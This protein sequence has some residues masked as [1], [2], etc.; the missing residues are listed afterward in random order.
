MSDPFVYPDYSLGERVA[1]AA[2]HAL[3]VS[4]SI[5]AASILLLIATSHA[6]PL[7][8]VSLTVYGI[9]LIAVFAFSAGYHLV[10]RPR[11][12]AMLR[13]FDH[14]AIFVMIAGTYTPFALISIGGRW[15]LALLAVVWGVAVLGVA[16]KLLLPGRFERVS[17][18][19]YLAQGWVMV[20]ALKP[21]IAAV[22]PLVFLLLAIGGVLYTVGVVFHVW[23]RLP[24]H[25]AIWHALVLI[26]AGFHYTAILA[27]VALPTA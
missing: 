16:W 21:L 9:G 17:T 25:N 15:G 7:S 13:R 23:R 1:D 24:Y 11:L 18:A 12:K 5:I 22:S 26:A 27:A 14:A 6:P 3:G 10:R 19:L 2:V 8:I 20:A 4:A